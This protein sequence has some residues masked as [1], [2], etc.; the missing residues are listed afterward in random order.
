MLLL[1]RLTW[2]AAAASR[3]P[4]RP[5]SRAHRSPCPPALAP[6]NAPSGRTADLAFCTVCSWAS[7]SSRDTSAMAGGRD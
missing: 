4:H 2:R 7:R 3:S 5:P 6:A 1:Q